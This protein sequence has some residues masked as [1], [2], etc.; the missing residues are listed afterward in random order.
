MD[1]FQ[2]LLKAVLDANSIGKQDINKIQK[3]VEK[4]AVN[5]TAQVDEANVVAE[6]RKIVPDLQKYLSKSLGVDIQINDADLLKAYKQIQLEA[7]RTA[8]AQVKASQQAAKSQEALINQMAGFREKSELLRQSEEK[9]KQSSQSNAINKSLEQEYIQREKILAKIKESQTTGE[10]QTKFDLTAV[11]YDGLDKLGVVTNKLKTDFEQLKI[12]HSSL[13]NSTTDDNLITNYE[14]FDTILKTV[15][16]SLKQVKTSELS[17]LKTAQEQVNFDAK[18]ASSVQKISTYLSENSK[19]LAET[20]KTTSANYQEAQKWYNE[21][22]RIKN[23]LDSLDTTDLTNQNQYKILTQQLSLAKSKVKELG[24]EGRSATEEIKNMFQKFTGWF[25]VSQF[26]MLGISKVREAVI[27]LKEIDTTLTEISKT[28]DVTAK[29]LAKIGDNSFETASGYGAKA[30]DYLIGVQEMSRAGY[31]N[32]EQMAELATLAQ[33]AGDMTAELANDY[34]IA[35]DASFK[36]GGDIEKL[37]ALLDGQN[38]I[39][40]RNAVSMEELANAT[41]VAGTLLANV[42]NLNEKEMS[43]I[44]GAGIASSR[45]SGETVARAV[46]GIFMNLQQVT[47]ESGFDGE[48]IDEEALKKVE[49][50]CH[51]VGVELEYMKDGIARLQDPM[52][53]LKQLSEVYNSLPKDSAERAGIIADIGGKYRGNTLASL[54]EN[55]DKVEKM[56]SDYENSSGSAMNEA[57][58]SANNFEGSLNRLSNTWTDTIENIVNSKGLTTTVNGF[59]GLLGI[60][61]SITSALGGLGT[62]GLIGGGILGAKNV[63]GAIINNYSGSQYE[64]MYHPY[65]YGNVEQGLMTEVYGSNDLYSYEICVA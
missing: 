33:S 31:K 4:Y 63:G 20:K 58:K 57:M 49:A 11:S 32:S 22:F 41:K 38:Q 46:K 29:N 45:E 14:K 54:L 30:N 16:N 35:S 37:N 61:N 15:N 25:G 18:R 52:V 53:T 59:N 65:K 5:I 44:L 62:A 36:Y 10:L 51:S 60:V 6:I 39:T 23:A 43:A 64:N 3:A 7:E 13:S 42:A 56:M 24:L 26:V 1:Q 47:G 50:R 17:S 40:N 12:V 2:I 48:I 28:A 55:F 19:L 21:I 8:K 34:L 27:E 9:R